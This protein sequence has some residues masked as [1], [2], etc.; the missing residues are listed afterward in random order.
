MNAEYVNDHVWYIETLGPMTRNLRWNAALQYQHLYSEGGRFYKVP[1][2]G[3]KIVCSW[4]TG[5]GKTK[6][7]VVLINNVK[8]ATLSNNV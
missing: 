7:Y 2:E 3:K 8:T 6:T 5:Y 4:I 1:L